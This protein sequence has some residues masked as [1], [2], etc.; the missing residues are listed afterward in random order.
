M[1]VIDFSPRLAEP[2]LKFDSTGA[3][4]VAL[5]DGAGEAHAYCLYLEPGGQIGRH[6]AGFGQL[7]LVVQ[8]AGWAA[9][10]DGIRVA[11]RSGQAACFERGEMHSKGSDT[12]MTAVMIQVRDLEPRQPAPGREAGSCPHIP[13]SA[14]AH[15]S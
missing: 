14:P 6:P 10:V 4:S 13:A 9:G 1:Q 2:I 8:G 15:R 3:S 12:G 7:F 5:G 11:L